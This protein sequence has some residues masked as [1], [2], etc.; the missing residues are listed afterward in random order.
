M[1]LIDEI[2]HALDLMGASRITT[3]EIDVVEFDIYDVCFT[4]DV[5][6]LDMQANMTCFAM[7]EEQ[8]E[9]ED[10]SQ[11]DL[12]EVANVMS[13][14]VDSS[15]FYVSDD[16]EGAYC[17]VNFSFNNSTDLIFS[18]TNAIHQLLIFREAFYYVACGTRIDAHTDCGFIYEQLSKTTYSHIRDFLACN[19][20]YVH[21]FRS[22]GNSTTAQNLREL[23]PHCKVVSPDLPVNA[24]EAIALL[25][26]ICE[27]EKIDVVV[28]TSMSGMLA[29]K[30]R[31]MPKVLVN[32]SFFVSETFKKNM[33]KV[34]YFKEREDG[35]KEFEITPE[36][37]ESYAKIEKR[38]FSRLTPKEIA[39]T[40]GAFGNDDK[41]VNCKNEFLEYYEIIKYFAGGHRLDKDA[42]KDRIIPAIAQ[43]YRNTQRT[44]D[45]KYYP[46]GLTPTPAE[47]RKIP[48]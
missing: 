20:L 30:L 13:Q 35:V 11:D 47:K 40:V 16:G 19:I 41:T 26:K 6:Q 24:E 25:R 44:W 45:K 31:G 39:I 22:T 34:S 3:C 8:M 15:T 17:R 9:E 12:M 4:L 43:L 46:S 2:V 5:S 42:L 18:I 27:E 33:G 28:G 48:F 23:Q 10:L 1:K 37:V 32:P 36:I 21:G 38:Q 14:Y 7:D 29:Q